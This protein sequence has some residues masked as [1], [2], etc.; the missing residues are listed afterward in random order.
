MS[1]ARDLVVITVAEQ[2]FGVPVELVRDVLAAPAMARIPLAP[3]EV[4]GA[5]NL[6]G[7]IVVAVD[8]RRR[9]G[10]PAVE[11]RRMCV[12]VEHEGELYSLLVDGIGEV[13]R[14]DG[15]L[16]EDTPSTLDPVWRRVS[17]GIYRLDGMLL[18]ALDVAR[19]L[20]IRAGTEAA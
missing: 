1:Q 2:N 19:T 16:F 5:L 20:D 11:L 18:L 9:L 14:V 17:A 4:A 3:A 13:L 8:L 7:R 15:D 6:R 12:V 10:L